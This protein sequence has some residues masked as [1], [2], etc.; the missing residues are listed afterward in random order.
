MWSRLSRLLVWLYRLDGWQRA[1]LIGALLG[2]TYFLVFRLPAFLRGDRP[3]TRSEIDGDIAAMVGFYLLALLIWAWALQNLPPWDRDEFRRARD[4]RRMLYAPR[5][6]ET[7]ARILPSSITFLASLP[8]QTRLA[9]RGSRKQSSNEERDPRLLPDL[10]GRSVPPREPR[11]PLGGPSS[12]T[13]YPYA[14]RETRYGETLAIGE[15]ITPP[16]EDLTRKE[17]RSIDDPPSLSERWLRLTFARHGDELAVLLA[18]AALAALVLS[19]LMDQS[20]WPGV[21]G[22]IGF[23]TFTLYRAVRALWWPRDTPD[24]EPP[25]RSRSPRP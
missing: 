6:V 18:S 11:G 17:V 5:A 19:S 22:A 7:T 1:S 10:P 9:L 14:A 23:V 13:P 16:G 20:W 4:E 21:S 24:P 8:R 12:A 25:T 3:F 15:I 2:P